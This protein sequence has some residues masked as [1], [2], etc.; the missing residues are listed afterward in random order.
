MVVIKCA[1]GDIV[2][3]P[4]A[5]VDMEVDGL[6][7]KVEAAVSGKLPVAVLL[8]KDVPEFDQLLGSVEHSS[9]SRSYR[10]EAMVVVTRAQARKQLEEELLRREKELLAGAKPNPVESEQCES[11]AETTEIQQEEGSKQLTKDQRRQLRQQCQ[12][13]EKGEEELNKHSLD[14]VT[15]SAGKG[16]NICKSARSFRWA[17]VLSRCWTFPEGG[18]AI[19]EVDTPWTWRGDRSGATRATSGVQEDCTSYGS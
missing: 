1:H 5:K 6:K 2:L 19:Q 9:E 14:V 12:E 13:G 8:G 7:V 15:G 17:S 3:Y 16:Y 10:E 11:G 4:L 18:T